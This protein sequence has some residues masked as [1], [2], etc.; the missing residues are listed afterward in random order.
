M[1]CSSLRPIET[2]CIT[3]MSA[4]LLR[5]AEH[6]LGDNAG[7]YLGGTATNGGAKITEVRTLP[8]AAA[9]RVGIANVECTLSPLLA[10]VYCFMRRSYSVPRYFTDS[11]RPMG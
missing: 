5:Q 10:A 11:A 1:A 9:H 4:S 6:V 3:D 8:E 7:L 2:F